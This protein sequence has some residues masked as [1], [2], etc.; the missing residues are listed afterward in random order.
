MGAWLLLLVALAAAPAR[1]QEGYRVSREAVT[2]AGAAD[3]K[4][5]EVAIGSS[6]VEA[7]GTVRPLEMRREADA[8]LDAPFFD[9]PLAAG[10]TVWGGVM[11]AGSNL[12]IADRVIDGDP[13]TYWEPRP[14]I[15]VA[16]WFVTLD[17]GRS[18]I[19]RRV[20]VRFAEDGDPF[21]KFRVMV[22]DRDRSSTSPVWYRAG[23]VTRPNK[24]QREFAF[25]VVP[26]RPMP[27]GVEG[28][29]VHL[30]RFEALDSDSTRAEE[31]DA[32]AWASLGPD[33]RGAVDYYRQTVIG[34]QI[35]VAEETWAALPDSQRGPVRYWRRERPRLAGIA[36]ETLGDN[37]VAITQR[38]HNRNMSLFDDIL[39]NFSTDGRYSSGY[40][41]RVY[42]SVRDRYQLAVDLGARFWLDRVRLLSTS[43]PLRAYQLRLSDGSVDPGGN[44]VW[45]VLDERQNRDGF[46][47]VEETFPLQEVRYL[48]LRRLPLADLELS[49]DRARLDEFQA[50]GEGYV[51]QVDLT[52]PYMELGRARI[53]TAVEWEGEAPPDTRI[54]VRTRSGNELRTVYEYY[55]YRG[56]PLTQGE[57]E[58]L[59]E[60]YRGEVVTR[61]E[62]GQGWSDWSAV[63]HASGEALRSPT[64]RRYLRAH[65][66]LVTRNPLRR[67]AIRRLRF[68]LDP[69]LVEEVLAEV[70]PNSGVLPGQD[71]EFTLY[72]RPHFRAGDTGFDGLRLYSSSSAPLEL[73]SVRSGSDRQLRLGT[74]R[75]L[76]PGAAARPAAEGGVSLD[77]PEPVTSGSPVYELRF[78]SR[79]YLSGT[80]FGVDLTHASRPGVAQP[81]SEGDASTLAGTQSLVVIAQMAQRRLLQDLGI[82]PPI[83]TPNGDGINE[84]AGIGFSVYRIRGER[85]L[86][87]AV[88][89]LAGRRL[90]D[91]SFRPPAPSGEYAVEWDGRDD[92]G[93]LVPPGTYL[94]R[95]RVPVDAEGKDT[96]AMGVVHVA[97]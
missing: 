58:S 43:R 19:A 73:E 66:R 80:V 81:V 69:P 60:R 51:S 40:S 75:Q 20:V 92:G 55:N 97:Y 1:G 34:R 54:E 32:E 79:V 77:L 27:E 65:V 29:V 47:Q 39:L 91:L 72:L 21:L 22:S 59:Q 3:W 70:T 61:R 15:P 8:V 30:V 11:E 53:V 28:D 64:P 48:E 41:M 31:V 5:W 83:L 76:Y 9:T 25:D 78:R 50:Y 85:T 96:E 71:Q 44:R 24:T 36:V 18:V 89:D 63:Y 56:Q 90:R 6:V 94:V 4:A 23:Q 74:A 7:D 38:I 88:Y 67:A 17:L 84:R 95:V 26:R 12:S 10:D 82:S 46:L 37:V 45:Q 57:W 2:V 13:A 93:R 33:D 35:R 62:P 86:V 14:T 87:A 68:V 16:R 49:D 52:S 42:D